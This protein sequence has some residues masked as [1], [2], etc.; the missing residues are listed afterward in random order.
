MQGQGAAAKGDGQPTRDTQ[1]QVDPAGRVDEGSGGERITVDRGDLAHHGEA[2][3][4]IQC[5]QRGRD[6]GSG[7]PEPVGLGAQSGQQERLMSQVNSS[8]SRTVAG[9]QPI[10]LRT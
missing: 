9:D 5:G 10:W 7:D 6:G 3:P 2:Q 4:E 1:Q 8:S